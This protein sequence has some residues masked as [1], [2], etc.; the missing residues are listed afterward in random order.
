[1]RGLPAWL[2]LDFRVV[3]FF[4]KDKGVT[5]KKEGEEIKKVYTPVGD[6]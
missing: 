4:L 1:L 5:T 3:V 6:A 2:G